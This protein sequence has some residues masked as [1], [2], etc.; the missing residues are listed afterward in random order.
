M[1]LIDQ[2]LSK[3]FNILTSKSTFMSVTLSVI[4]HTSS[5]KVYPLYVILIPFIFPNGLQ[6]VKLGIATFTVQAAMYFSI[7]NL[8]KRERPSA[9]D[10][11]T[12]L[13]SPPD[14]YS[15]PSGHSASALLFTLAVNTHSPGLTPYFIVWMCIVWI[16]RVGLGLHYISDVIVGIILG[17]ISHY[18]GSAIL[19]AF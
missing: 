18:I 5:G 9:S 3:S 14:K 13:I 6:I 1:K 12:R 4:T 11:F 2:N 10:G 16:S 15:M 7:K 19:T 17:V 8:V